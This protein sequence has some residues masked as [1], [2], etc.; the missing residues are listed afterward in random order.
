MSR[1][2][3]KQIERKLEK[4]HELLDKIGEA[5]II[6]PTDSET[7]DSD[8]LANLVENLKETLAILEDKENARQLD[9]YGEPITGEIGLCSLVDEYHSEEE[10]DD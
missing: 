6:D 9:P 3:Q 10:A 7:W 8:T 5:Q 4:L 2:L 1:K